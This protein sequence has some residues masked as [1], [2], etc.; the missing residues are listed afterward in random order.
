MRTKIY[1]N[2]AQV[3]VVMDLQTACMILGRGYDALKKDAREGKFPA[4]KNGKKLWAV[5]KDDLLEYID[6]QK[7]A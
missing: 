5:K 7:S 1:T 4:F 2:W 6:K 3:P